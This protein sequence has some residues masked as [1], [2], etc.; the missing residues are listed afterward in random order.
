MLTD[1]PSRKASHIV[2]L[3]HEG[4]TGNLRMLS[5]VPAATRQF[6][7]PKQWGIS[8]DVDGQTL[9]RDVNMVCVGNTRS[10][11]GPIMMTSAAS[12]TDGVLDVMAACVRGPVESAFA[13]LACL[14]RSTHVCKCARYARGARVR[15]TS[16]DKDVPWQI[17]GDSGGCLP[18]E[19]QCEPARVR[20]LVP[21]AFR[22]SRRML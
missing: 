4:R 16:A 22:P 14:L 5:Y 15:L 9:I 11:G 3:I 6:L 2:N 18:V 21:R 12:P 7:R 17:D 20:L 8:V 1:L 13:S 19:L 10:Y